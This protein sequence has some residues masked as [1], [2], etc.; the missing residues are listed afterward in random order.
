[1]R[2]LLFHFLNE[3]IVFVYALYCVSIFLNWAISIQFAINPIT[4]FDFAI[5][6]DG[7]AISMSHP[8]F[9]ISKVGAPRV[10]GELPVSVLL[11]VLLI[12]N[13]VIS[14]RVDQTAIAMLHVI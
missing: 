13:I 10:L 12:S 1:M 9:P 6:G 11:V 8:I 5:F 4:L 7:P 14:T 2:Y 3:F